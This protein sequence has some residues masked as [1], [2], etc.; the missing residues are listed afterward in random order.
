[1]SMSH[2]FRLIVFDFDGTLVDSQRAILAAM[3]HAFAAHS[4]AGPAPGAVRR[5]VGLKLEIAIARLLPNPSD[6]AMAS[7]VADSYRSAYFTLRQR[8]DYEE[9]LFP[10]VQEGLRR[11]DMPQACLGIATG[12][13]RRGLLACLERHDIR[14]HFVTLQ[15]AEDGPSKPHPEILHLAMAE[16]GAEPAETVLVG[17]TTYDMEMAGNAGVAAI[18]VSWGYHGAT[19]LRA[20]GAR[21]IVE[22]FADLHAALAAT[23]RVQACG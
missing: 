7:R 16:V 1:M 22:R 9:P 21:R 4:L 17:D 12:K 15:T 8:P 11:L 13:S 3:G 10:G 6:D 19:E 14:K 23:G 5:I 2:P 18:G 20:S